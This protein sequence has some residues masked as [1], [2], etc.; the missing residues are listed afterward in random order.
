ML[1]SLGLVVAPVRSEPLRALDGSAL[2][3]RRCRRRGSRG[4]VFLPVSGPKSA[5]NRQVVV[6]DLR[7][8]TPSIRSLERRL[9]VADG[10]CVLRK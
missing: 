10:S 1:S 9:L 3:S 4:S 8:P 7:D 5:R 6:V 2:G